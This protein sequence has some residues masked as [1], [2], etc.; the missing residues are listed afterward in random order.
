MSLTQAAGG[1][2]SCLGERQDST[3]EPNVLTSIRVFMTQD[4]NSPICVMISLTESQMTHE[5]PD[6]F[7]GQ[8]GRNQEE[9]N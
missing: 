8:V 1:A 6:V 9:R 3:R 5:K 2:V 7:S 4:N